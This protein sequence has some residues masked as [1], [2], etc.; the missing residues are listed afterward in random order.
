MMSLPSRSLC[1]LFF[2]PEQRYLNKKQKLSRNHV[3]VSCK[4]YSRNYELLIGKSKIFLFDNIVIIFNK[5]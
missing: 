5:L 4:M 2:C 1:S 3:E